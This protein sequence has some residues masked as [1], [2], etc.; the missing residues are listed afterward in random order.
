MIWIHP[1]GRSA[2][3]HNFVQQK[4]VH[5]KY[6]V[7]IAMIF[8]T[9]SLC[10]VVMIYRTVQLGSFLFTAG[11]FTMPFYY[12]LTDVIAEVYGYKYARQAT[13]MMFICCLIFSLVITLLLKLPLPATTYQVAD[14]QKAFGHLFRVV[15]G[16]TLITVLTA[17]FVNSYIISKWK[18]LIRGR[19]FWMRSLGASAIGE[20]VEVVTECLFLYGGIIPFHEVIALILPTYMMH[21]IIGM[22]ILIPGTPFVK[23]LKTIEGV[24]PFDKG[25]SF[26]PFKFEIDGDSYSDIENLKTKPYASND[27]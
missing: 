6:F 9:I 21:I 13:W 26:N 25:I 8:T 11:S 1:R 19:Y 16:G 22:I 7:L 24:D 27:V 4:P 15:I 10:D 2:V 18:I 12:F 3:V 5:Y 23:F 20:A 14:Y 17:T